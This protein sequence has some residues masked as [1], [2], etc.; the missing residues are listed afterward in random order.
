MIPISISRSISFT[1]CSF[2]GFMLQKY[3]SFS[4]SQQNKQR[5]FNRKQLTT[6]VSNLY[7]IKSNNANFIVYVNFPMVAR[8]P[9]GKATRNKETMCAKYIYSIYNILFRVR[10]RAYIMYIIYYFLFIYYL[11]YYCLLCLLLPL[12]PRY[13]GLFM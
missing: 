8:L 12:D 5:F 1:V 10:V 7:K 13:T 9:S 6:L 11:Y 4:T 2:L 3:K